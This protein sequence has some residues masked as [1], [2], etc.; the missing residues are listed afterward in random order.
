[1][2][3]WRSL[4]YGEVAGGSPPGGRSSP[5]PGGGPGEGEKVHPNCQPATRETGSRGDAAR[6]VRGR[7]TGQLCL[8][9]ADITACSPVGR[10]QPQP[11]GPRRHWPLLGEARRSGRARESP[12]AAVCAAGAPR[13]GRACGCPAPSRG[14][15]A[16]VRNM[17]TLTIR[18]SPRSTARRGLCRRQVTG[19]PVRTEAP[20]CKQG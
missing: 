20:R 1:M 5:G 19:L 13:L 15:T 4:L 17:N 8:W 2:S 10:P 7:L 18:G 14:A 3:V 16:F 11:Q 6:A 9:A 12:P